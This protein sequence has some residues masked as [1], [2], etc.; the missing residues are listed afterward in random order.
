MNAP[1]Q[2]V[3]DRRVICLIQIA[4]RYLQAFASALTKSRRGRDGPSASFEYRD[5]FDLL[6]LSIVRAG[7]AFGNRIAQAVKSLLGVSNGL[8]LDHIRSHA[9]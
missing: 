7:P 1:T 2:A 9:R 6:V 5:V 4:E 3:H 8:S